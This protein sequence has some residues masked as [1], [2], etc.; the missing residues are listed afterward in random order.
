M[1][2]EIVCASCAFNCE[3]NLHDWKFVDESFL[4]DFRSIFSGNGRLRRLL[5]RADTMDKPCY[6]CRNGGGSLC[7]FVCMDMDTG[8]SRDAMRMLEQ[9][10]PFIARH[11]Y[12]KSSSDGFLF[13]E[14][15]ERMIRIWRQQDSFPSILTREKP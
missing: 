12:E 8:K 5:H 14:I 6:S 13:L 7:D 9:F 2:I 1:D 3:D 4:L 10:Y 15:F 11:G